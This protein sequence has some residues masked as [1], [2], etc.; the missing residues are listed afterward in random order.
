MPDSNSTRVGLRIAELRRIHGATQHALAIRASVSYSLLRKVERAERPASPSFI[1]AVARALD[2]NVLDLTEQPYRVRNAHPGS[3]QAGVPALRQAL[4]EGDD[5]DLDTATRSLSDLRTTV[6]EVKELDR[7][8]KHAEVVQVLPDVLRHLHRAALDLPGSQRPDAHNHLAAAY[9]YAIVALY[10]LGHLDLSHLADERARASAARGNDPLWAAVA[11]WNHS[12]ILMFDGAFS[13]GLRSID[14][15]GTAVELAP[16]AP[17]ASAVRGALHLRAAII[18]AR[19]TDSDLAAQHLAAAKSLAADGQDEANYY[20]TKFGT[21]NVSIHEV[22][23][24]VE[25]TDG[26][27]AI[28]RAAKVKLPPYTAPSRS[29]HYW[30]DLSRGWLLHGDRRRALNSLHVARR[31]APQLTRYHPQVRETVHVL[32]TQETRSSRSLPRF[33][34]WCGIRI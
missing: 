6:A 24:P 23:V 14:R 10:R 15:A 25:L 4:V 29:G 1:A 13:A 33:A 30:I 26:T 3:E 34:A 12:L 2:V 31:V 21:P 28:T 32:A 27:T 9:S 8:T 17:A 7:Q 11:E 22:A 5:P 20:G 18:A 19:A 16:P